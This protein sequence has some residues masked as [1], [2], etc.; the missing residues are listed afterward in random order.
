MRPATRKP[1]AMLVLLV[2]LAVYIIFAATLGSAITTA[3]GWVQLG[4]FVVAG[5]AWV[6]PI[7]PLFGWMNS[8]A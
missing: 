8:G 4:F 2:W 5:I 7:K 3:P 1:I 6:I